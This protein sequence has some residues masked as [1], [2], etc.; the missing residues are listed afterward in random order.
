MSTPCRRSSA[1][2][3][4]GACLWCVPQQRDSRQ[5]RTEKSRIPRMQPILVTPCPGPAARGAGN[6]APP[7]RPKLSAVG[8]RQPKLGYFPQPTWRTTWGPLSATRGRALCRLGYGSV[9]FDHDG[10][11]LRIPRCVPTCPQSGTTQMLVL[12]SRRS[13]QAPVG[14]LQAASGFSPLESIDENP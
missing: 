2:A 7:R 3:A 13:S 4:Q 9:M 10:G 1:A 6:V 8:I 11:T 14:L 5:R 12:P